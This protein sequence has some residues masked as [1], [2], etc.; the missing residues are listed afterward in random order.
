MPKKTT[1]QFIQEAKEVHK[2]KNGNPIYLYDKVEYKTNKDHVTITCRIHGDFLQNPN[3]HLSNKRGC[4]ECAMVIKK[5]QGETLRSSNE[6][7]IQKAIKIH[8]DENGPLF[9]Y[10]EVNY[11]NAKTNVTIKC[12][13]GHKFQISPTNHLQGNSC[14]KCN[15]IKKQNTKNK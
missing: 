8:F 7:F 2:D 4:P 9:N 6:D 3:S 12:R 5:Q 10:D 15:L 13:E 1:E 11:V 14:S